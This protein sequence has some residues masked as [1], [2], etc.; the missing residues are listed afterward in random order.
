MRAR[1]VLIAVASAVL[2]VG[3]G[4]ARADRSGHPIADPQAFA[5]PPTEVRPKIRWWW[6]TPYAAQEFV[7]EVDAFARAGFGGAEAAFNTAG[8]ATAEQREMLSASLRAARRNRIRLDMTLGAS[9]PVTTPNTRPGTGLSEQEVMYGRTDLTG[10]GVFEVAAPPPIGDEANERSARLIAVTAARV[11][12]PGPPVTEPGT[13]PARSTVLDPGSLVDLS[14]EL[15]EDGRLRWR[16]PPG[17][18]ILF[19]FWQRDAAEGVMDHLSGESLEAATTYIDEHQIGAENAALVPVAAREFFE[20]S[21][22]LDAEELLWTDRFREEFEARRGYD[23]TRFL[24]LFYIQGQNRYWVPNVTPPADFDLP[25][26][27]G[28]RVRHDYFETLTDLYVEHHIGG[29]TRWARTHGMRYRTQP[30]FGN[31]FDV[32]RSAREVARRGGIADDE[33]LNAG[34]PSPRELGDPWPRTTSTNRVPS[35][36]RFALDHYRSVAGGAHQGGQTQVSSEL[37]AV[38][39]EDHM[40]GLEDYKRIMDKQW[41]AGITRPIIH[42]YAYQSPGSPWPGRS[43]FFNFIAASWNHRTFPQWSMFRPLNEYWARGAM[44]LEQGQPRADVAI[45]RDGF[46]TT[47]ANYPPSVFGEVFSGRAEFPLDFEKNSPLFDAEALELAGYTLEYID[48]V[49][50]R[51]RRAN[52]R[53]VLYPEGPGYRALVIDERALPAATAEAIAQAAARDLA[54]VFVGALPDRGTSHADASREDRRV[55]EAVE[56]A[57]R[58]RNVHRASTQASVAGVLADMG[59]KPAASWSEPVPVYSQRRQVGR[60]EYFYLWNAGDETQR[61]TASFDVRGR[62]YRLNLWSGGVERLA[63]FRSAHGRVEVPIA[64]EPGETTVLAFQPGHRGGASVVATSAE[65]VA[66]SG[67]RS[68]EVRDTRGGR[69]TVTFSDGSKRSVALPSLPA[70]ITP[71]AWRLRVEEAGPEGTVPHD[72]ELAALRDWREIPAITNA[73]GT[74]TYTTTVSLPATWVAR[75]RGTYL[76]LGRVEGAIQVYVNGRLAAHNITAERRLDL[77][78]LLRAGENEIRIVL[79]TMLKNKLLALANAGD[80]GL[81]LLRFMPFTEPYGLLGPVQL[82]PYGTADVEPG[83]EGHR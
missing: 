67:H 46:V 47:A 51:D 42:G 31:A 26:G 22:E 4:V 65:D 38:F 33:S 36:W 24:P 25:G 19:G 78:D 14:R 61:F 83:G 37:G 39:F 40:W 81:A 27:A 54:V 69:H 75:N 59:V 48:P 82:V 11:V 18:W 41:A 71:A 55:Q 8:W 64:L 13:P 66:A 7:D 3:S 57:L 70:P 43:Q 45:Y 73:S 60:S 72:L 80:P 23:P 10:P 30:A 9:W 76:E 56:R 5:D 17:D 1:W 12:E 34:D 21:L 6:A 77:S 79:T 28:E 53:G 68:I 49:G 58:H 50:V 16:V 74:G 52:G 63:R 62:P 32:T 29:F 35:D 15:G 44:V 20:D 2:L